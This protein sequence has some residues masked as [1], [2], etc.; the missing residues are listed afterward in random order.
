[1]SQQNIEAPELPP[2]GVDPEKL[3]AEE[4]K[5]T[6]VKIGIWIAI[7][8]LGGVSWSFL[9]FSRDETINAI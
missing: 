4:R 9:A 5:W 8:L 2:A 7:A 6:P 1:M 3:E